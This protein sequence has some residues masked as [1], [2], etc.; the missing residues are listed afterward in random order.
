MLV[1]CNVQIRS[2]PLNE[3]QERIT[4]LGGKLGFYLL[5]GEGLEPIVL[6][7]KC[8]SGHIMELCDEYNNCT[9]FQF[10][11]LKAFR[12]ISF[13]VMLHGFVSTR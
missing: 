1:L 8:Q 9:Q 3:Q 12:D 5:N 6:L 7:W 11:T 4:L 10:Y 2:H 13:F